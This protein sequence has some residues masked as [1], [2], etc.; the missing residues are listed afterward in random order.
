M[1]FQSFHAVI[2]QV[3]QIITCD[4]LCSLALWKPEKPV[5]LRIDEIQIVIVKEL[6][7]LVQEELRP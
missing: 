1:P 6:L 2:V 5:L 7:L 3:F 4:V